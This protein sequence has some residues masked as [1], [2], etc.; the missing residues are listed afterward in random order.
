V[1]ANVVNGFGWC[2]GIDAQA[3]SMVI[4][5]NV[6][7]GLKSN[8]STAVWIRNPESNVPGD[9][10]LNGN[11]LEG[12]GSP[13][14]LGSTSAGVVLTLNNGVS[15]VA[16]RIRNN[17]LHGGL[18]PNRFGVLEDSAVGKQLKPEKLENNDFFFGLIATPSDTFYGTWD[19]NAAGKVTDINLVNTLPN[20]A[21]NFNA[22][23]MIDLF[24]HLMNG[25][26]CIDKGTSSEAPQS[27]FEGDPRPSGGGYDVGPDEY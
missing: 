5:N 6:V 3:T 22:D 10:A 20:S 27:D 8:K 4:T 14:A 7:Y 23:P 13:N 18:A 1:C 19:G 11:Y 16:G 17:I 9:V 21:Q 24:Y 15:D 26:P 2:G 12:G 25:S